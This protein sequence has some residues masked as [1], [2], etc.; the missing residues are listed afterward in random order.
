MESNVSKLMEAGYSCMCDRPSKMIYTA[1]VYYNATGEYRYIAKLLR[2][3]YEDFPGS[4]ASE[5]LHTVLATGRDDL[6][7]M[8]P[9]KSFHVDHDNMFFEPELIAIDK[10]EVFVDCGAMDMSTSLEFAYLSKDSFRRIVAFDPDPICAEVCRDNLQFFSKAKRDSV[11]FLPY[12]LSDTDSMAPFERA[13]EIGNSRISPDGK[14]NAPV[15]KLDDIEECRDMTFLKVHTE[16]SE[17]A[18]L[19]GASETIERNRPKIAVSCYHNLQEMFEIPLLL[20]QLVPE[21]EMYMRHYSSGT[22]ESVLYAV[23]PR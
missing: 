6:Q 17:A 11:V 1:Q 19:R 3:L 2:S 10:D 9:L 5:K 13:V 7:A 20:R 4:I 21:Y 14:E 8:R 18:V 12:G 23:L 22:S 16:G 15:R